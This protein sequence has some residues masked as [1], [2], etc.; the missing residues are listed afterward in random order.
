MRSHEYLN[1]RRE[2]IKWAVSWLRDRAAEMNDPDP[3]AKQILYS[4]SF[5]L[6]V[7]AKHSILSQP[8][9][10]D[11]EITRLEDENFA[12]SA[13]QCDDGYGDEWGNHQCR[14]VDAAVKEAEELAIKLS[15]RDAE[16]RKLREALQEI[17]EDTWAT[18]F[19]LR[20]T[21]RAAL[22]TPQQEP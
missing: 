2:A 17:E 1:G 20:T 12:L 3:K 18:A 7:N 21:A 11:A 16:I 13:D 14:R 9:P 10:R 8:D 22:S 5:N 19:W 4:A 15:E 6:G